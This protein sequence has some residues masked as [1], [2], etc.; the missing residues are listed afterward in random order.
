LEQL[1]EQL[2]TIAENTGII[3]KKEFTVQ[4]DSGTAKKEV[5]QT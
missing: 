4:V 1:N 3:A 2:K 5:T